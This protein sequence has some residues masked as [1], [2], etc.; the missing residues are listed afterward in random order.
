MEQGTLLFYKPHFLG[1]GMFSWIDNERLW[2]MNSATTSTRVLNITTNE[3]ESRGVPVPHIVLTLKNQLPQKI[4]SALYTPM[5]YQG[6]REYAIPEDIQITNIRYA[7][8]HDLSVQCLCISY[9][10]PGSDK[11]G[12]FMYVIHDGEIVYKINGAYASNIHETSKKI[13]FCIGCTVFV[14]DSIQP[15]DAH[16]CTVFT[17]PPRIQITYIHINCCSTYLLVDLLDG[18]VGVVDIIK[19]TL[20]MFPGY[21]VGSTWLHTSPTR[22]ILASYANGTSI[23]DVTTMCSIMTIPSRNSSSPSIFA[24]TSRMLLCT[25]TDIAV[26][27]IV[28]PADTI[29]ALRETMSVSSKYTFFLEKDGDKALM[30]KI[31][32]Y[33]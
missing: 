25:N 15:F 23:V 9:T 8:K 1:P 3:V 33:L 6:T 5:K 4:Y 22:C 11:V 19:K 29:R 12:L 32:T 10:S 30:D 16:Q 27:N 20:R 26:Y 28:H 14:W 21:Y 13:A 7:M 2:F 31:F 18:R 24:D 17:F